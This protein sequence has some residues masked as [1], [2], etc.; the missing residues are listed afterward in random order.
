MTLRR[1]LGGLIGVPLAIIIVLFAVA[2]RQKVVV[3]FDPFAPDA[4]ALSVN[5]PL[6]AVILVSLM[7]GVVIGGVASWLR[8]GKWR[9]EAKR[10]RVEA[11]RLEAEKDAARREV[12]LSRV[13][14]SAPPRHAA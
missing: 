12:A 1:L 7:A 9:K 3:G 5:L 4:P 14:L 8:Q 13:A 6:F 2:N 11:S 10:R